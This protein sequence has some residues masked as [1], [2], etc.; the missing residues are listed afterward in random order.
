MR[1]SPQYATNGYIFNLHGGL[2]V[3]ETTALF[4]FLGSVFSI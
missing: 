2:R 1:I 4:L 3:D